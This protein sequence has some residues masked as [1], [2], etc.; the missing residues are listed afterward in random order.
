MININRVKALLLFL[1]VFILNSCIEEP[2][3]IVVTSEITDITGTSAVSGGVVTDEGYGPVLVRG[4]CWGRSADPTIADNKT[5]NGTGAGSFS[6]TISGLEGST[7][8]Y[9]RAYAKS[10]IG[11][12]YGNTVAF[13]TEGSTPLIIISEATNVT[14][15]TAVLNGSVNP[16]YFS[17]DVYF[18]YG[19]TTNYGSIISADAKYNGNLSSP[20]KVDISG[21]E[22]A[23]EYHIRMKAENTFGVSYS[24][25]MT[26]LTLGL[27]PSAITHPAT[28][29][30]ALSARFKGTVTANL[31][32][33]VVTFEYGKTTGYGASAIPF[34]SSVTGSLPVEILADLNGLEQNSTYHYRVKAVNKVG[35]AYG[36]DMT[37]TTDS[38]VTD[39]DGNVYNRGIIGT[40]EWFFEN[41]RT[42]RL[43]DGTEIPEIPDYI[44]WTGSTSPSLCWYNNDAAASKTTYGAL[45]NW[46]A[47]NTGNLCP[48]GWHVA[49]GHDWAVLLS[50]SG[51]SAIAGKK[52]K[53]M[54]TAHWY[55]PNTDATNDW[56]FTALPGGARD[57]S[58]VFTLTGWWGG[59][60][61][62]TDPGSVMIFHYLD[63]SVE[64][65]SVDPRSGF[66][67]RCVKND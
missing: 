43:N 12:G 19:T 47:V 62:S 4:V 64:T 6:S 13:S 21:L 9:V 33:T 28:N 55:S 44:E 36:S 10:K 53:E 17:T 27:A 8:Y 24:D 32:S 26:F 67:V 61:N 5:S 57:G 29:V 22:P 16:N 66:S 52:L 59:I 1:P 11:T 18:E 15:T 46:H 34:I 65:G 48:T 63:I 14:T 51:G 40:Q 50:Y 49:T 45:Y 23:T 3:P 2:I 42:T 25:D 54:G 60:W 39:I 41:L 30:M 20:V 35:I 31:V 58:G 7:I 38:A 37:F 56:G